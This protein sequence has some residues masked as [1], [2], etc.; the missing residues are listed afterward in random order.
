MAEAK[1]QC[2][3]DSLYVVSSVRCSKLRTN[4]MAR[5]NFRRKSTSARCSPTLCACCLAP[6]GRRPRPAHGSR[7]YPF[8]AGFR[9]PA[10]C[11]RDAQKTLRETMAAEHHENKVMSIYFNVMPRI[12][13][14]FRLVKRRTGNS[15]DCSRTWPSDL[16]NRRR[17]RGT[18]ACN[19]NQNKINT[20]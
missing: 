17:R 14:P 13:G 6:I 8:L 12:S 3:G 9:C 10:E 1:W 5:T 2:I 4:W 15:H 19:F 11:H 16:E 18:A 7:V 20:A